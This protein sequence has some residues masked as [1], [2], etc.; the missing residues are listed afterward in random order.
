[1][2]SYTRDYT[3]ANGTVLTAANQS[4]NEEGA[5][6]YFN[7][8]IIQG[9]ILSESLDFDDIE[10]GI[11]NP[12]NDSMKFMS[13]Y[14]CGQNKTVYPLDAAYFTSTTK[15]ADQTS[16]TST[17]Y[18]DLHGAGEQIYLEETADVIITFEAAFNAYPNSTVSGGPGNGLWE[19]KILLRHTDYTAGT[20]SFLASTRGYVFEGTGTSAGTLDPDGFSSEERRYRQVMFTHRLSLSAGYHDLQVCINPKVETGKVTAR[21][22]LI[23]VY[24]I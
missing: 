8:D 23:E 2:S 13:G 21:N 9:D 24:Y 19:N 11:Y 6:K 5:K 17:D 3:Y 20:T 10:A 18:Q 4:A 7:Q 15:T 12:I 22:L 1:M 16:T 14:I